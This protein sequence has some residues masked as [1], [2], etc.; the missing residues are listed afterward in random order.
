MVSHKHL[1]PNRL[2]QRDVLQELID[3]LDLSCM[4]QFEKKTTKN[5]TKYVFHRE[6]D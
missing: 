5:L 3:A 1:G 4:I 2:R 6:V